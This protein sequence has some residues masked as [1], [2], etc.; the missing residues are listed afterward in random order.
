MGVMGGAARAGSRPPDFLSGRRA[1]GTYSK[2]QHFIVLGIHGLALFSPTP[3]DS[4]RVRLCVKCNPPQ[5]KDNVSLSLEGTTQQAGQLL[6][7]GSEEEK[8]SRACAP[9]SVSWG[10]PQ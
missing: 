4:A 10:D 9:K 6:A 1:L 5:F 7:E 3:R 8:N 2:P